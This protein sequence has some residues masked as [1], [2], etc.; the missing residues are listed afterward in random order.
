MGKDKSTISYNGTPQREY[1]ADLLNEICDKTYLSI[2]HDQAL[3]ISE[4]S[5]IIV[6]NDAHR[7]PFNGLLSAHAQYPQV[8]WL[9]MACDLPLMNRT[10]L[11]QLKNA[12]DPFKSAT[13][14]ATIKSKLPEPLAAIWEPEGLKEAS[15]YLQTAESSC[16]RKFLLQSQTKLIF[17]P[18]DS[19]LMNANSLEDYHE[20]ML[21]MQGK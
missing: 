16:P 11:M 13:A 2:R 18:D 7:G 14:L 15:T 10:T 8:A 17:P 1:M 21:K 9:V 20:V 3:D 12:R 5:E 4:V 6:D 19:V